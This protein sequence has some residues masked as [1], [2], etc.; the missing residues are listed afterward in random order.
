MSSRLMPRIWH[1]RPSIEIICQVGNICCSRSRP[2]SSKPAPRRARCCVRKAARAFPISVSRDDAPVD[3]RMQPGMK[4]AS[5]RT[6]FEMV[7]TTIPRLL[8][9]GRGAQVMQLAR[10]SSTP[11][12]MCKSFD[13]GP[14]RSSKCG[15]NSWIATASRRRSRNTPAQERSSSRRR[16]WPIVD[17]RSNKSGVRLSRNVSRPKYGRSSPQN[18]STF[19]RAANF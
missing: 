6:N 17:Q 14:R 2:A 8:E 5:S 10:K 11:M 19:Y 4:R 7:S 12:T 13:G 16:F 3:Q 9:C 15:N 18:E 1:N